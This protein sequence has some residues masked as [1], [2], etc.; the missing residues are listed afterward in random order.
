MKINFTHKIM[1]CKDMDISLIKYKRGAM[2][3]KRDGVRGIYYPGE[4]KLWTRNEKP[5]Y[6]M[7]HIVDDL[8]TASWPVDMEL[9]VP[10]MEFNKISGIVRNHDSSPEIIGDIIDVISPGHILD[11]LSKRRDNTPHVKQ[12]P[13][14][15]CSG[16]PQYLKLYKRFLN[17]GY[18]GSVW[19][20]LDQE[21]TNSRKWLR[22]VPVKNEDCE[23]IGVYEGKGKMEGIAGGIFI[24]FN[25]L[26]CKCGTM[27]NF[28]YDDRRKLLE[29]AEYYI[30]ATAEIQYKNL[31]TSGN[32]S[33]PRLKVW[34][35]DK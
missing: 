30:G 3:P 13:H 25:G 18:E 2:S 29:N 26:E 14:Y 16:V 1:N 7:E 23:V 32:P 21:Y 17:E 28:T 9:Y 22:E 35:Y 6:G 12:I 19:K 31:Q 4:P 33:Q 34:R 11:R 24:N 8:K 20:A 10:G 5:I 27:K 15:Y